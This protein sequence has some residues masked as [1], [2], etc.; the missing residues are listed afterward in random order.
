MWPSEREIALAFLHKVASNKMLC[1]ED[2]KMR[3]LLHNSK[4]LNALSPTSSDS[5]APEASTR[6]L[7]PF[8]NL[9]GSSM[10][11]GNRLKHVVILTP[12][13]RKN[14]WIHTTWHHL[15]PYHLITKPSR[16]EHQGAIYEPIFSKKL[17]Q[18]V[19]HPEL[20]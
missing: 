20:G 1:K 15:P 3:K 11:G 18:Y 17:L 12:R 10:D 9:T 8:P 2:P 5:R 4:R 14:R 6:Q 16:N 7:D 13:E 19:I